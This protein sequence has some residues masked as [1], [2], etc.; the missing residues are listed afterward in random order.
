MGLGF[1]A[2][3]LET[4]VAKVELALEVFLL[5]GFKIL[6]IW[7]RRRDK[8]RFTIEPAGRISSRAITPDS[9]PDNGTKPHP[10]KKRQPFHWLPRYRLGD[11]S[12]N[13][14]F[15]VSRGAPSLPPILKVTP[16]V[17]APFTVTMTKPLVEFGGTVSVMEVADQFETWAT[18]PLK[19]TLLPPCVAP[20]PVPLI[21][22]RSA[23]DP[24]LGDNDAIERLMGVA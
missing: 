12:I 19:V 14:Q 3:T 10:N 15:E 4:P 6:L 21:T 8:L 9:L 13:R 11:L 16:L 1:G 7:N 23:T 20:K 5:G 24:R 17:W 2:T 18:I 22:T